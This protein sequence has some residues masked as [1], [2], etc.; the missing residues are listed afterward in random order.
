MEPVVVCE[1]P[2]DIDLAVPGSMRQ[3]VLR[4]VNEFN[5]G[6][7]TV[8][9]DEEWPEGRHGPMQEVHWRLA[10]AQRKKAIVQVMSNGSLVIKEIRQ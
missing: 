7:A 2:L 1:I 9:L 5:I 8:P 10:A 4:L 3:K 6:R